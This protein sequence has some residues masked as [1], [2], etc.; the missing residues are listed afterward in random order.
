[1]PGGIGKNVEAI[2]SLPL[3]D[4]TIEAILYRNAYKILFG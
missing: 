2:K 1:M 4:R 3:S